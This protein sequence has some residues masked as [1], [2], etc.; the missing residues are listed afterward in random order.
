M[1]SHFTGGKT[2][3]QGEE[4]SVVSNHMLQGQDSNPGLCQCNTWV[5]RQ[6][7]LGY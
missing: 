7:V 1:Y 3:A 5:V 6:P 2:E 4:R